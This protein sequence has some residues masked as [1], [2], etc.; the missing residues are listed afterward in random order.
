MIRLRE[1]ERYQTID[2]L[3]SERPDI[4]TFMDSNAAM[5]RLFDLP[6]PINEQRVLLYRYLYLGI[7]NTPCY[8]VHLPNN[9]LLHIKMEY[10]NAMGNNHYSR[11]WIPYLFIAETLGIICPGDTHLLE[12]T[13]GSAGISLAMAARELGYELTLVIPEE[14][15]SGR[16]DPMEYYGANLVKVPG[17]I[18]NCVRELRKLLVKYVYFPCNHSEESADILVKI[19]RRIAAEFHNVVGIPDYSIV[20]LGN[21]TS[22]FALFSYWHQFEKRPHLVTY[23]PDLNRHDIVYGLYGPNVKL[24]HVEPAQSLSDECLITTEMD[25]QSVRDSFCYD[26][27]IANLGLS[28]LY[29]VYIA[30]EKSRR[31]YSKTFMT[32]GYDKSDR[33][34]EAYPRT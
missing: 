22:T 5:H 6:T 24:R 27:E 8:T 25:L 11:C 34:R 26:T 9:N 20:G 3:L 15:P 29:G 30:M 14:L 18:D 16:T 32:I 21:G 4:K 19:D 10:A 12:V 28:S 17:Y 13:S 7:G 31:V 2:A 1:R 33:Y 23:H